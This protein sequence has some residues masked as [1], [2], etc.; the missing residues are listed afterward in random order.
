MTTHII[1]AAGIDTGKH[2]LDEALADGTALER[3]TNDP[4]GHCR[5]AA[6]L[7][8]RKVERVGIEA[9][10]GYERPVVAYL[11]RKG[12]T[13]VLFQPV[14]VRAYATYRLQRAKNDRIDAAL[15]AACT[16]QADPV[17]HAPDP[18]FEAFAEHMTLI[19]QIE[20]DIARAKTRRETFHDPRHR[21]AR[22][23]AGAGIPLPR[24]GRR[25]GR[26]RPLRRR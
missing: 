7:T 5:L 10:G 18:R 25:L 26:P 11:R 2:A 12:F 9:S 21:P 8:R 24:A 20:E 15:I 13:V 1:T 23:H 16:A 19:E 17:R 3:V 14:Q 4:D 6:W 22:P